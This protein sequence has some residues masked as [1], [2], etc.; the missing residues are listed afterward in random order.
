MY[1]LIVF[2][3]LKCETWSVSEILCFDGEV[4]GGDLHSDTVFCSGKM[5]TVSIFTLKMEAVWSTE[6]LLSYHNTT[7]RH[8][9]ED[10]D[11]SKVRC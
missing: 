11:L 2:Q 10:H 9:Q 7:R 1:Y 8:K 3:L 4:S 6:T 5:W